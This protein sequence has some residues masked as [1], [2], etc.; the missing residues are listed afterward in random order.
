MGNASFVDSTSAV[1]EVNHSFLI[2]VPINIA[3]KE[4]DT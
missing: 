2:Y 4:V 3:T 1:S